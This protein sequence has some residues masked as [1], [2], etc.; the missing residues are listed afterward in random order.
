MPAGR[1][2]RRAS[3]RWA[4]GRCALA[5]GAR[6][7]FQ[8]TSPAAS[9]RLVPSASW[10]RA[11]T[12][13]RKSYRLSWSRTCRLSAENLTLAVAPASSI[14]G[15]T[16]VVARSLETALHKLH[17]LKFDLNQVVSRLRR[18]PA[19]AGRGR[20]RQ[21]HRPDQ[22]RDPL[23]RPCDALGAGRRRDPRPDRPEGAVERVAGPRRAFRA[24]CSSDTMATSTRSTRCCSRRPGSSSAT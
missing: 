18:R 9:S 3:S 14:A 16:Q 23:R 21:S 20:R 10:N 8:R 11:S 2:S 4:R 13:P 6:N 24:R 15:T 12:R 17:E 22:R 7:C 1:S 19:A 5:A